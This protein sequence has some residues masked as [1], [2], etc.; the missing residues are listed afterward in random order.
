MIEQPTS[1]VDRA[2]LCVE[3]QRPLHWQRLAELLRYLDAL[4]RG[5]IL[6]CGHGMAGRWD[7]EASQRR[8]R[9]P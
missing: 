5:F 7:T 2:R 9:A 4:E 3:R 1:V 8:R 6:A